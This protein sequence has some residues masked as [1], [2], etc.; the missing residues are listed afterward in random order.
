MKYILYIGIFCIVLSSCTRTDPVTST[1]VV[2][3]ILDG[4]E[5][6]QGMGVCIAP[7]TILTSAHVMRDDRVRYEAW[8][9]RY[10]I[11]ERDIERDIAY[12]KIGDEKWWMKNVCGEYKKYIWKTPELQI[13]DS[14]TTEVMRSGSIISLTGTIVSLTGT[15]LAYDTLWRTQ[16]LTGV[17]VTDIEYL[18]WDSGAPILDTGWRVVDVV[19]TR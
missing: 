19:H 12:M 2:R 6:V 18:P 16:I 9:M 1:V 3:G 14:I 10:E 15:I 4:T 13:G 17:L 11:R 7:D 8:D 5:V